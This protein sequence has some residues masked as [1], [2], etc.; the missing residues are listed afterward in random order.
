M[1]D[2]PTTPA[3][4]K[5]T[6]YVDVHTP[7]SY[8]LLLKPGKTELNFFVFGCGGDGSENQKTVAGLM[9]KVAALGPDALPDFF[10]LLGD[11][12]Y[13]NGVDSPTDYRFKLNFY[14]PYHNADLKTICGIPYF[15]IMGNHDYDLSNGKTGH[16]LKLLQGKKAYLAGTSTPQKLMA[17]VAHTFV[18]DKGELDE[19]YQDLLKSSKLKVSELHPWNMPSRFYKLRVG[20][21]ELF[22]LDSNYYVKEFLEKEKAEKEGKPADPNN[23]AVWLAANATNPDTTKMIF[24]HHP[25]KTFGKRA[26]K[27]YF[28]WDH[29]LSNDEVE[30]LSNSFGITGGYNEMLRQIMLEHQGLQF[31]GVFAAHDH[32]MGYYNDNNLCQAIIG[33][34]GGALQ[35][36]QETDTKEYIP[37][38]A[39]EFGFVNVKLDA[40]RP[41]KTF[42]LDFHYSP[43]KPKMVRFTNR[44]LEPIQALDDRS[45]PNPA[46]VPKIKKLKRV[47]QE[48]YNTYLALNFA[49]A[50]S[51]DKAEAKAQETL[52]VPSY[53]SSMSGYFSKGSIFHSVASRVG[54]VTGL[55]H[56][57]NGIS[58]ADALRNFFNNYQIVSLQDC[59]NFM[60]DCFGKRFL[61]ADSSSLITLVNSGLKAR[62]GIDYGQFLADP[63]K[64][65][66]IPHDKSLAS[67]LADSVQEDESDEEEK[68]VSQHAQILESPNVSPQLSQ[69]SPSIFPATP[70]SA[71]FQ[72]SMPRVVSTLRLA[73]TL[74]TGTGSEDEETPEEVVEPTFS[75]SLSSRT[76]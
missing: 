35:H 67:D 17:Q 15:I 53:M 28:D 41:E 43:A 42:Q 37:F 23:Q 46:D 44:S 32:V 3:Q 63:H 64:I 60:E 19:E 29:Y 11:N 31:D 18:N 2:R 76:G 75:R 36:R 59:R 24:L 70:N 38:F 8:E 9:E 25:L 30:T 57:S 50:G 40:L 6:Q 69:Y 20:N 14:H 4:D 22:L 21:V 16:A 5:I 61:D 74:E 55:A 66:V 68:D 56:G 72:P 62:H 58:R 47:I 54:E 12:F 33:S 10:I 13:N 73:A 34:G 52:A 27:H 26:T 65:E 45:H 7:R 71:F 48:A 1:H 39:N 49:Y 51:K